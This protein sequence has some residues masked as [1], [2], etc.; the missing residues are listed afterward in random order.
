MRN[1]PFL[2]KILLNSQTLLDFVM[3]HGMAGHKSITY[4]NVSL[5]SKLLLLIE[6]SRKK[7]L[8]RCFY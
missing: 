5:P 7:A 2:Y 4:Y 6:L 3:R 8:A 1:Y